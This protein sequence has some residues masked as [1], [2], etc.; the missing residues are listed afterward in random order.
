[1]R[2]WR[3]YPPKVYVIGSL[4]NPLIPEVASAIRERTGF[5]VFDDWYAAG[6]H[7]DDCW[8]DYEKARGHTYLEAL[9]GHAAKNVFNFDRRHLASSDAAVLVLPAGK[10]GHL[11]LGWMAGMGKKTYVLLEPETQAAKLDPDWLWLAG[12]YEGEGSL[13]RNGKRDG[14]GMQLTV[15]MED[16]DIID[17]LATV[18]GRG[19]VCGPYKRDNPNWSDMWRWAVRRREDVLYVVNGM[20][21]QLGQRRKAQIDAVL[22]AAGVT[23]AERGASQRPHEFRYDVMYQFASFVTDDLGRL[24]QQLM[25]DFAHAIN[26]P[27]EKYRERE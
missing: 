3:V 2:D 21:D 26:A 11:E 15:T 10:S 18:A 22:S 4:R 20:W 8:R 25:V 1:M 16:K 14:H 12:I 17:R 7:A 19:T 6:P 27:M 13:T 23:T 24:N 9:R 5:E